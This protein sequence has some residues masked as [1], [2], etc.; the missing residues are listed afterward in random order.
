[1]VFSYLKEKLSSLIF[2]SDG[3]LDDKMEIITTP[4]F[5]PKIFYDSKGRYHNIKKDPITG[6]TLPAI[7]Y[8]NGDKMW[9]LHGKLHRDDKDPVTGLTLPA[10]EYGD[11]GKMWY[12]KGE[13]H[14]RDRDPDTGLTLPAV[15]VDGELVWFKHGVYDNTDKDPITQITLPAIILKDGSKRWFIDGQE[16][17]PSYIFGNYDLYK[18][19]DVKKLAEL[20]SKFPKKFNEANIKQRNIVN[21]K[22]VSRY[23]TPGCSNLTTNP[24][25]ELIV[26]QTTINK[27]TYH[28]CLTPEEFNDMKMN[29]YNPY[30]G[31][32]FENVKNDK[33]FLDGETRVIKKSDIINI[34]NTLEQDENGKYIFSE[35]TR[36]LIKFWK[37]EV[38][39]FGSLYFKIP[40]NI[41]LELSV[42]RPE[43]AIDLYRGMSFST[44]EA[45]QKFL[46]KCG[47]ETVGR[48]GDICNFQTVTYTSWTSDRDIALDF[49][50][51]QKYGVI[52][53]SQFQPKDIV[54]YLDYETN[55][56]S[57][58]KEYLI[59]PGVYSCQLEYDESMD[60]KNIKYWGKNGAGIVFICSQSNEILLGMRS[61]DVDDPHTWGTPGGSVEGE[62]HYMTPFEEN[63]IPLEKYIQGAITETKEECGDVPPGFHETQISE[64]Y[65]EYKD[66]GF[67]YITFLADINKRQKK[68]W[69][70]RTTD[71]ENEYFKWFDIDVVRNA[72]MKGNG[73]LKGRRMHYGLVYFLKHFFD[74]N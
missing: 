58:E 48:D 36:K 35:E 22:D 68:A 70:I 42:T 3:I 1:M 41:L 46:K 56:N 45:Y 10:V 72:Y 55:I 62:Q 60:C 51:Y 57:N 13:R 54:A 74:D 52:L 33:E 21:V 32:E 53:Y 44:A 59:L 20:Y 19:S 49:A 37:E 9:Y 47:T 2:P 69:T 50:R 66:C 30:F 18:E 67:K 39:T 43:H 31:T 5:T 17:E 29:N 15:D 71:G 27:K 40:Y 26:Y 28:L 65:I 73:I 4:T 24:L 6:L 14:N 25:D 12:L 64:K 16:F 61:A 34:K 63:Y 38:F 23:L 8:S 7:E 11:G